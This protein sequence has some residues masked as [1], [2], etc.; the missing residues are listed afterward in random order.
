MLS[1]RM[2]RQIERL[3]D[4][5]DAAVTQD[6][7][8]TVRQ[9]A[10]A[11]LRIEPANPDAAAYIARRTYQDPANPPVKVS[12]SRHWMDVPRPPESGY[13]PLLIPMILHV[14]EN[15]YLAHLEL[16]GK[17]FRFLVGHQGPVGFHERFDRGEEKILSQN[18]VP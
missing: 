14:P 16:L 9:R 11:V 2:R 13:T 12:L 4:Q 7:W 8:A 6:D 15:G 3:L 18:P 17:L 10:E 1:E 5:A